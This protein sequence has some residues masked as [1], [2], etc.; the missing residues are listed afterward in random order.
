VKKF[1]KFKENFLNIYQYQSYITGNI[2]KND[3]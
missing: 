2:D 1:N 3:A